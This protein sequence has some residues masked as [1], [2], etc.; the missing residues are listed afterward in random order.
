MAAF[1]YGDLVEE[2]FMECPKGLDDK[3]LH[4]WNSVSGTIMP[5]E[6][7]GKIRFYSGNV[8]PCLNI[9]KKGIVFIAIYVDNNMCW[10]LSRNRWYAQVIAKRRIEFEDQIQLTLRIVCHPLFFLTSGKNHDKVSHT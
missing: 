3:G 9:C 5:Q 10:E 1:L 6:I 4:L 2:T 8:Y 7:V